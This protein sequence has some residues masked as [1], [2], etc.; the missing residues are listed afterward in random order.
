MTGTS[1]AMKVTCSYRQTGGCHPAGTEGGETIASTCHTA[2]LPTSTATR[3]N[4]CAST[5]PMVERSS[6]RLPCPLPCSSPCHLPPTAG[7]VA[8]Q[9]CQSAPATLVA[10][11]K[12]RIASLPTRGCRCDRRHS[13]CR[14][15]PGVVAG[16]AGVHLG[17][18]APSGAITATCFQSR[19]DVLR[20]GPHGN[21]RGDGM[22]EGACSRSRPPDR[23]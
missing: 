7:A 3:T 15:G 5:G 6:A 22:A 2:W 10:L 17:S 4:A 19:A 8:N 18:V 21:G 12:R 23:G 1:A 9:P 14:R 11:P 16:L 20:G 13:C